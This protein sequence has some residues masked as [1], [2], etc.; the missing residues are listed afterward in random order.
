MGGRGRREAEKRGVGRRRGGEGK[1]E[2]AEE[3]GKK[4]VAERKGLEKEEYIGG[5]GG[6]GRGGRGDGAGNVKERGTEE[7]EGR[8]LL[9]GE[10]GRGEGAWGVGGS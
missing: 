4:G 7:G 5:G 6:G 1:G 3:E 8:R 9:R 10:M 2:G